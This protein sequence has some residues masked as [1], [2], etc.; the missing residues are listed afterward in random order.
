MTDRLRAFFGRASVTNNHTKSPSSPH[1]LH[2]TTESDT[3]PEPHDYDRHEECAVTPTTT[4]RFDHTDPLNPNGLSRENKP[5]SS[6][7]P[8]D[9]DQDVDTES[10]QMTRKIDLNGMSLP[11]QDDDTLSEDSP[12]EDDET[13][14]LTAIRQA[15][16]E[17]LS[18]YVHDIDV[19]E[20]TSEGR[21][22][23][24]ECVCYDDQECCQIFLEA[25]AK[26]N[27]RDEFGW[28]VLHFSAAFNLVEMTKFLLEKGADPRRRSHEDKLPEEYTEDEDIQSLL[29]IART[30]RQ[31]RSVSSVSISDIEAANIAAHA[32]AMKNSYH[33]SN[34]S[35]DLH[36]ALATDPS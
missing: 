36:A 13:T 31:L 16:Y 26:I 20:V 32:A 21:R 30:R 33:S 25:G 23:I 15:D 2:K 9:S 18:D 27:G 1:T 19:N 5:S 12:F 6:S 29:S 28:T 4:T 11:S 17:A 22:Y 3:C 35:N 24:H 14:L 10:P 7:N 34:S 8:F